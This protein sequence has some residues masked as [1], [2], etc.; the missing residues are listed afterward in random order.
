MNDEQ[1]YEFDLNGFVVVRNASAREDVEHYLSVLRAVQPSAKTGKFSFFHLD[2]CFMEPDGKADGPGAAPAS[3]RGMAALRSRL[4]DPHVAGLRRARQPARGAAREP[5][6][7][8][9][10]IHAGKTSQRTHEVIHTLSNI[11]R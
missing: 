2:A 6:G 4:R 10:S 3:A 7:L 5:T 9:L 8:L 1:L 11:A